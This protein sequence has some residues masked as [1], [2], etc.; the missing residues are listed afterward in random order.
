M[1]EIS[2]TQDNQSTVAYRQLRRLLMFSQIRPG[3]RLAEKEWAQRLGVHR[4]ALREAM[5]LLAHEGLLRPGRRGGYF[6]PL[7]EQRDLDEVMQVRTIIEVGALRLIGARP[8]AE[9]ESRLTTAC[10]AMQQMLDAGFELGFAEADRRFHTLLVELSHNDRLIAIHDRA[11]LPLMPSRL[12]DPAARH[13]AA[14]QTIREHRDI[15]RLTQE[16]RIAEAIETLERHL[17]TAHQ[18]VPV[19]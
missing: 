10:D 11:P 5:I 8:P 13:Q 3:V 9:E 4:S 16:R 17:N 2:S 14:L 12:A 19:F 7:L 15:A 1:G 6:T 18:L